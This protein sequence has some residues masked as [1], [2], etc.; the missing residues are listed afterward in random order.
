M[1]L[2]DLKVGYANDHGMLAWSPTLQ[3]T[4]SNR[5]LFSKAI[6][7]NSKW[8]ACRSWR[9]S[10]RLACGEVGSRCALCNPIVDV[11]LEIRWKSQQKLLQLGASCTKRRSGCS[12]IDNRLVLV[13]N[14]FQLLEAS[15]L[16]LGW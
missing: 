7:C 15:K 6:F 14:C 8:S 10:N 11:R 16:N 9:F 13:Q 3:S 1:M 4:A 12:S 2:K 5:D